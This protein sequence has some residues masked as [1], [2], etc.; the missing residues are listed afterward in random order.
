MVADNGTNFGTVTS[1]KIINRNL[2]NDGKP[3]ENSMPSI[4]LCLNTSNSSNRLTISKAG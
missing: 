3:E 1:R 4:L 2:I